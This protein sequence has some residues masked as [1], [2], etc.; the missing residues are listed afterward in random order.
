MMKMTKFWKKIGFLEI[1]QDWS[2]K[3]PEALEI[4]FK[5]LLRHRKPSEAISRSQKISWKMEPTGSQM[6]EIL[7]RR[8]AAA[9]CQKISPG[10][11]LPRLDFLTLLAATE[12]VFMFMHAEDSPF[13]NFRTSLTALW[14]S[15]YFGLTTAWIFAFLLAYLVRNRFMRQSFWRWFF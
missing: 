4:H 7:C 5:W 11:P 6:D 14:K 1:D 15:Y 9:Q 3:L 2:R 12:E 8:Y 13:S 10:D